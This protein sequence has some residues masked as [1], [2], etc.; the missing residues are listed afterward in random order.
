MELLLSRIEKELFSFLPG[1][2]E[3]YKITKE[4]EWKAI[5]NL[6]EDR[7]I[8]I[9]PADKGSC[10]VIWDREDSFS[11]GYRQLSDHSTYSDVKKFNQEVM[12]EL[13]EKSNRIFKEL[14]NKKL[15][16][17]KELKHFSFNF[18]NTCCLGKMYLLP[19]IHKRLFHVTRRPVISNYGTPTEKVSE[20]LEHHLQPV[21]KGG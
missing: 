21:M 13:T 10:V 2:P 12:S 8:I 1:K 16:T 6:A 7:S 18:K 19:K 17:E 15:I 3:S 14:C 5:C 9:K 4:E 11:E 20:F